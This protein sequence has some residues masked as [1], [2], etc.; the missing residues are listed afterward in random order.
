MTPPEKYA[1]RGYFI[2]A[3]VLIPWAIILFAIFG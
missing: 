3:G 1:W 2:L